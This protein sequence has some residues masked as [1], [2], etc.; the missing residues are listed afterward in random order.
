MIVNQSQSV[1]E[2]NKRKSTWMDTAQLVVSILVLIVFLGLSI[3]SFV[4]IVASGT[5]RELSQILPTLWVMGFAFLF[6]AGIA[7]VSV[8]SSRQVYYEISQP[9]KHK[10]DTAWIYWSIALLPL[11][12]MGGCLVLN[13]WSVPDFL[14]PL[15]TLLALSVAM[16]WILK[17]GLRDSLGENPKR[18]SG[19]FSFSMSF[20]TMYIMLV[21][22]L[23][24]IIAITMVLSNMSN[25]ID[26]E[27][28][29]EK[30][31]MNPEGQVE[32]FISNPKFVLFIML[33]IAVVGPIIEELFKT[34]GVWLLKPRNIS[35]REGWTA[36]LMSGAGFGLIEGYL[37]SMQAVLIPDI[38]GWLYFVLG[39]VGGLLLHTFTGGIVGWGLAKSWR[40]KRP[41]H[42][43]W[44]YLI[45]FLMHG[46]WNFAAVAQALLFKELP[47]IAVYISLGIL[48]IG[49]LVA[50]LSL[51]YKIT[52]ELPA[53][54]TLMASY[55]PQ[56][57][58]DAGPSVWG[59]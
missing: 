28:M 37:F 49:M 6:L 29:L 15:I 11:L 44:S 51:S 8:I 1:Q 54:N 58:D 35:P 25:S 57:S 34:I 43:I 48:F 19:L 42:A 23:L 55:L 52:R 47:D 3:L 16:I 21:Q 50:Y 26:L 18:D 31:S 7:L 59:A 9:R 40:E 12:I 14:L 27:S 41:Q 56:D 38:S 36:G 39:R 2:D 5:N 17:L 10:K 45:A 4:G 13:A 24:L 53:E 32:E 30:L 46:L 33:A 22:I 20:S